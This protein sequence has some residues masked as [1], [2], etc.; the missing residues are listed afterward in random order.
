[1]RIEGMSVALRQRTPWEAMDLGMALAR[2]HAAAAW[3]PWLALSVP[4]LLLANALAWSLDRLWLAPLLMWWCKPVFERATLYVLSRAVFGEAPGWRQALAAPEVWRLRSLLPWLSW[5][6]L[7]PSRVLLQPVDLLEDLA[8]ERRRLRTGVLQRAVGGQAWGLLLAGLAF[9]LVLVASAWALVLLLFVP[10]PLLDEQ[11]RVMWSLFVAAPP[12]WAQ[13][14]GN[15]ALWAAS[16]AI[17]PLVVGAGFGLYLN[18]RTQ[19]EAWDVE[20][21]FRRLAARVRTAAWA[22]ALLACAL[23]VAAFGAEP[24]WADDGK[25]ALP[26]KAVVA[27]PL[28]ARRFVGEG[29]WRAPDGDFARAVDRAYA[30]PMLS[31]TQQVRRWK[32]K[33]PFNPRDATQP[34]VPGWVKLLS[35][36]VGAVAEYGL[37]ILLAVALGLLLWRL[38]RWLPW[39]RE[40]MPERAPPSPIHAQ[41]LPEVAALPPDV[42]AS[43]EAL[44]Q[45]G[46]QREALALLY[47][48]SVEVVA[49]RLGAPFPPGATEADCLR[50]ARQL[51]DA[52]ASGE[53][54]RVVR[55][56]QAAAYAWRFPDAQGFADLLAGWRRQF[57]A[58]A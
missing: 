27:Q 44:W 15:A 36:L 7:H 43:A 22:P 39:V 21:V 55:A 17:G 50:R 37:W 56:W 38:P 12:A 48:A 40:R 57:G 16:S 53:F 30:D 51:P 29:E 33:Y 23:L 47:R 35:R 49:G 31:P 58:G 8:G 3:Q 26:A 34:E 28:D 46:Q 18:R 24:A 25:R 5:R 42:A 52:G 10:L 2:R 54:A 19:L 14:L 13:L 32:Y 45:A 41:P 9:E 20:L 4:V 6:R 11:T 1:M